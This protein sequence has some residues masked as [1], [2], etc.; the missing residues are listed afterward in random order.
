MT[1]VISVLNH[2]GGVGKTTTTANISA[3]LNLL[4]KKVL[5]IDIDP[6]ANL[7]VHFGFPQESDDTI[8]GSLKNQTALPVRNVRESEGSEG[9]IID[10]LDIVISSTD[11]MADIELQLLSVVGREYI[12]KELLTP[13]KTNYDYVLID[14]PPSLG[15]LP[16]NALS[17]S[18]TALIVVEPAKFSLDGMKKIF[19]AMEKVQTR[20]NP[21]LKD[22]RVLLTRY[23]SNKIIHQNVAENIKERFENHVFDTKIRSNV[24]LEE[25]SMEGVDI[26]RYNRKANG[27]TDYLNVCEELIK[28]V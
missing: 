20:I 22:Y 14:C 11:D 18:D 1:K 16:L 13:V 9:K 17:C 24:S 21:N 27:A 3:G 19:E 5:M 4:G 12:L 26:F 8:Y 25:A 10:G 6:Q 2:K 15:I 28:I 23:N 7:T